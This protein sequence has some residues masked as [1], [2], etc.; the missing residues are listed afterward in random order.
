MIGLSTGHTVVRV[1]D[2]FPCFLSG[3]VA[4]IL[5]RLRRLP[6]LSGRLWPLA[7]T[8]MMSG[9]IGSGI[10]RPHG[11]VF[12]REW[13]ACVALGLIIPL[14]NDIKTG[15]TS[16][17]AHIVARYSYGIYLF[18]VPA[19]WLAFDRLGWLGKPRA[20]AVFVGTTA[21]LSVAAYHLIEEPMIRCGL[22]LSGGKRLA[23]VQVST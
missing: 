6:R 14:F 19:L 20:A 22:W 16:T 1:F 13:A 5:I 11:A 9:Y 18:H 23:P 7:L 10:G 17:A 2:Y 15:F 4:Y 8:V 21:V 3:G 12:Y